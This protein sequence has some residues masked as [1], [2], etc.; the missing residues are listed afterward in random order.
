[1][2]LTVPLTQAAGSLWHSGPFCAPVPQEK[3]PQEAVA[4]VE[5]LICAGSCGCQEALL[6]TLC[7]RLGLPLTVFEPLPILQPLSSFLISKT[8]IR[9]VWTL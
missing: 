1:M 7:S 2:V 6:R 9:T 4:H 8:R 3:M 5:V